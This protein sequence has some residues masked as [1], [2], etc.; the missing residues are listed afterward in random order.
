[1]RQK[2]IQFVAVELGLANAASAPEF[3]FERLPKRMRE[4]LIETEQRLERLTTGGGLEGS[5]LESLCRQFLL[6][7]RFADLGTPTF[8]AAEYSDAVV[9]PASVPPVQAEEHRTKSKSKG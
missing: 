2:H 3:P 1:M 4:M 6:E 5:T 7:K 9:S 8:D